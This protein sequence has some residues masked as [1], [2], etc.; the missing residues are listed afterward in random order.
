MHVRMAYWVH[1]IT[2]GNQSIS[3]FSCLLVAIAS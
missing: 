3:Y 2:I 1:D